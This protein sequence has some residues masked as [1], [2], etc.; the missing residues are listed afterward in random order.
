MKEPTDNISKEVKRTNCLS[1]TV[2]IFFTA[3]GANWF[4]VSTGSFLLSSLLNPKSYQCFLFKGCRLVRYI[5]TG[6]KQFTGGYKM[7]LQDFRLEIAIIELPYKR[8]AGA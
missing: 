1:V 7:D 3:N 6:R 5:Q 8:K 2:K 4:Q